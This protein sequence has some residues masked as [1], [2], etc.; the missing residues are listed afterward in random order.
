MV[1]TIFKKISSTS[2]ENEILGIRS[3]IDTT[4]SNISKNEVYFKP[5]ITVKII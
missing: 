4:K 5:A 3:A 1:Q 2:V